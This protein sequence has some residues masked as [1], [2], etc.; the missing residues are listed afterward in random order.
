M[1]DQGISVE[2]DNEVEANENAMHRR[3]ETYEK[4]HGVLY[5]LYFNKIGLL[6]LLEKWE[7]ILGIKKS[8]HVN[9]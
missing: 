1:A 2:L 7:E 6:D 4:M 3:E 8:Q 5:D 9:A